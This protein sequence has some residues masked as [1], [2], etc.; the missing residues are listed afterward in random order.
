[1]QELNNFIQKEI[2]YLEKY[3]DFIVGKSPSTEYTIEDINLSDAWNKG[4]KSNLTPIIAGY[5]L[6][7]DLIQCRKRAYNLKNL[8]RRDFFAHSYIL[9]NSKKEFLEKHKRMVN[10]FINQ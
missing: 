10:G 1:M 4:L 5:K 2:E 6:G 3:Q 7:A 8:S 9:A